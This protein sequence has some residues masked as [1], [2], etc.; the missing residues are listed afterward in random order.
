VNS[1]ALFG[2]NDIGNFGADIPVTG[3]R[4]EARIP[5]N[6][7]LV[8]QKLRNDGCHPTKGGSNQARTFREMASLAAIRKTQRPAR[9]RRRARR[10]FHDKSLTKCVGKN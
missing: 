7:F 2:G 8:F 3:G 6:G 1:S 5:A 10:I 9:S 4:L